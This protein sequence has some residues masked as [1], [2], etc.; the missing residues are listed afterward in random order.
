M[1][2]RTGLAF[3]MGMAYSKTAGDPGLPAAAASLGDVAGVQVPIILDIGGK[4]DRHVFVGGYLGFGLGSSA[5]AFGSACSSCAATTASLG[6]QV[7]YAILPDEW[8]N[9]WVGYGLGFSWFSAGSAPNEV[10]LRGFDFARLTLGVDFRLSR[11][12]GIGPF[13]DFDVGVYDS[14]TIDAPRGRFADGDI[15]GRTIHEWLVIGPRF[16]LFP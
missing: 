5:G 1:A 9:P 11:T 3:P 15:H 12:L 10:D 14:R 2:I 8:V 6:A 13:V 4:P 16:V 7:H